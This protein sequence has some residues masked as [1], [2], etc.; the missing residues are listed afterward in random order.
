MK[1]PD[2]TPAPKLPL[3]VSTGP[4]Q[5]DIRA[6]GD[7]PV[8]VLE[9]MAR[10]RLTPVAPRTACRCGLAARSAEAEG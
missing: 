8:H 4:H 3:L 7:R 10:A 1:N 2:G 6:A 5:G 9:L